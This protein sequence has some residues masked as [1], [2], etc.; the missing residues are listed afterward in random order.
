M[1]VTTSLGMQPH[2][3][4]E[5]KEIAEDLRIPYIERNKKSLTHLFQI[6]EHVLFVTKNRL[7]LEQKEGSSFFFHLDT[8]MLR[9]KAP[10]DPLLELI[11][12]DIQTVLDCTMG[13]ATDSILLS[14]AG[15]QVTALESQKMIAYLVEAGLRKTDAGNDQINQAMRAIQVVH[16]DSLRF[17][18]QSEDNSFDLIY[19]DPMFV[20]AIPESHNLDGLNPL[21]NSSP[22]TL[23]MV[24]EAKRVARYQILVK[25]HFRDPIFEQLGFD[26]LV[27]PNQKFHY[28]RIRVED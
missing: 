12:D 8:A 6:A 25:A 21:A 3:V 10:R 14:Y 5:A 16:T 19:F 20:A 15:Y 7:I 28:G 18:K 13:M 26:H 17:L 2:L 9:I 1:I 11:G 22:L 23:E 4:Q 24:Q 27:R